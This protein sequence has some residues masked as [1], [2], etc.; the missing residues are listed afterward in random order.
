MKRIDPISSVQTPSLKK[1]SILV[2]S[3]TSVFGSLCD[4]SND[5]QEF[6]AFVRSHEK[7]FGSLCEH[8]NRSGYTN[9]NRAILLD[10][11]TEFCKEHYL[12]R[13]TLHLAANL[14]DRF[15]SSDI[16]ASI[17]RSDLQPIGLAAFILSLKNTVRLFDSLIIIY[18]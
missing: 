15:M 10:W 8:G 5:V 1:P 16:G 3:P 6:L 13:P 2:R 4:G 7:A 18:L 12:H 17:N 11:M 14:L 9:R